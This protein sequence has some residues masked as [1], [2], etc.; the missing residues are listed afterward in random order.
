MK[1]AFTMSGLGFL[2]IEHAGQFADVSSKTIK[3]WIGEG[4]PVYQAGP[5]TRVLIRPVD[6]EN[7]L[8]RRQVAKSSLD[9]MVETVLGE[10]QG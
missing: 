7:F 1:D 10:L 9:D 4:L 3:R 8:T 2:T 5:R 6:V